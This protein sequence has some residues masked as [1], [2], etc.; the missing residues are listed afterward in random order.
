VPDF[1][2]DHMPS[3]RRE[4]DLVSTF[5]H[6]NTVILTEDDDEEEE[7]DE[8]LILKP[9]SPVGILWMPKPQDPD[10]VSRI[11]MSDLASRISSL[12]TSLSAMDKALRIELGKLQKQVIN[13]AKSQLLHGSLLT[14]ILGMLKNST[15]NEVVNPPPP[16]SLQVQ[17]AGGSI[18]VAGHG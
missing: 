7:L 12:E 4:D 16:P 9:S 15:L 1:P 18:G 14:E 10:V 6:G 2:L 8:T 17:D 5:H 11:S 13:Q 3:M